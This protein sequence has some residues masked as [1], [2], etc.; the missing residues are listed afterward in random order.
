MTAESDGYDFATHP[1]AGPLVTSANAEQPSADAMRAA[2]A[3]MATGMLPPGY[4]Q[5]LSELEGL[6]RASGVVVAVDA[7]RAA[8]RRLVASGAVRARWPNPRQL[9]DAAVPYRGF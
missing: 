5:L 4:E 2:A 8:W 1:A 7:A 3:S 9:A 6:A